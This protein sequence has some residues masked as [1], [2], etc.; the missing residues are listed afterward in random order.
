MRNNYKQK[1]I[2]RKNTVELKKLPPPVVKECFTK[3]IHYKIYLVLVVIQRNKNRRQFAEVLYKE[4]KNDI[5]TDEDLNRRIEMIFDI[6]KKDI[7]EIK[8]FHKIKSL[9]NGA[10]D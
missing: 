2:K 8:E 5:H 9:G 10:E 7:Y 6:G 3:W 1:T 4:R